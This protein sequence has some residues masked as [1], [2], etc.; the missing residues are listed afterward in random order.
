MADETR[1]Q[2]RVGVRDDIFTD[3]L[4][5][6]EQVRLKGSKC[7]VCGEVFL[8]KYGSCGN[9]ANA[10]MEDV[11][12]GDK[13][14]L[15]TYTVIRNRPPGDYK[16]SDPF[17][18]FGEGLIELPEGIRLLTPLTDCDIENL[19]IGTEWQLVV[20][21]LYVDEEGNEVMSFKF[22]PIN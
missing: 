12:L 20:D 22:K 7:R 16:G 5:P 15:W 11:V 6:S 4:Y 9:C 8:G 2:N 14:K 17:V 3:P 18:P 13:G 10:D 21:V 19:K 1:Q